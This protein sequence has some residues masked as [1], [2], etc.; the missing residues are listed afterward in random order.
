[1]SELASYVASVTGRDESEL[2]VPDG[3]IMTGLRRV[4][5]RSEGLGSGAMSDDVSVPQGS[6]LV[7]PAL[8]ASFTVKAPGSLG[9]LQPGAPVAPTASNPLAT[10]TRTVQATYVKVHRDSQTHV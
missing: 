10:F 1:V 7:A 9:M 4:G 3:L 5:S 8:A 6:L 2:S